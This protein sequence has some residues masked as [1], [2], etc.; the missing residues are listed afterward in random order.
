[1]CMKHLNRFRVPAHVWFAKLSSSVDNLGNNSALPVSHVYKITIIQVKNMFHDGSFRGI[2]RIL[3]IRV[4]VSVCAP[5]N[6]ADV[7]IPAC[8]HF[9]IID[10][11]SHY[12]IC[13]YDM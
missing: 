1:M 6:V 12:I 7:Y 4:C 5:S 11:L 13:T 8:V 9:H 3:D 2:L 10:H